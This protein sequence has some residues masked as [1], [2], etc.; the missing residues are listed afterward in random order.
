[1]SWCE[2][3]F[4]VIVF[5]LCFLFFAA[6][7]NTFAYAHTP[8]APRLE[9]ITLDPMSVIDDD[10]KNQNITLTGFSEYYYEKTG[11]NTKKSIFTIFSYRA[12]QYAFNEFWEGEIPKTSDILI[13]TNLAIPQSVYFYEMVV[14]AKNVI[15]RYN[16]TQIS[17]LSEYTMEQLHE[18]SLQCT[19]D[20]F[21][22][23]VKR[24]STGEEIHLLFDSNILDRDFLELWKKTAFNYPIAATDYETRAY[25]SQSVYVG[26]SLIQ[27]E[28]YKLFKEVSAPFSIKNALISVGFLGAIILLVVLKIRRRFVQKRV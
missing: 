22:I 25:L 20:D 10:G 13:T 6:I 26:D 15:F 1:M 2:K 11:E 5:G 8:G 16:G 14:G 27:A 19:Y 18:L 28:P 9:E 3:N 21:L 24:V 17:D 12:L 7:G 4:K 23:S